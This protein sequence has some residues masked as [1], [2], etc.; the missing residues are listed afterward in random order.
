MTANLIKPRPDI[1]YLRRRLKVGEVAPVKEVAQTSSSLTL[2][3]QETLPE[4]LSHGTPRLV[5]DSILKLSEPSYRLSQVTSGVG[6]MVFTNVSHVGWQL[7]DGTTG[8]LY[9]PDSPAKNENITVNSEVKEAT[10]EISTGSHRNRQFIEFHKGFLVVS[11]RALRNIK[12][13]ILVPMPG[14]DIQGSTQ[15][16]ITLTLPFEQETVLY[17]SVIDS[18]LE[19]RLEK[20]RNNIHE[21][22][23]IGTYHVTK[24]HNSTLRDAFSAGR[25]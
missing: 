10:P 11:L 16:Q 22:Y 9:S 15:N 25:G 2:R 5:S 7:M 18:H 17:C 1:V 13:F 23:N 24:S 21:T 6:S 8:F 4:P 20:Y 12:R 19:F 3:P 14:Q